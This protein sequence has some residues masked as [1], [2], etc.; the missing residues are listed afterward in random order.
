MIFDLDRLLLC[1]AVSPCTVA[2]Q[3]LLE[4]VTMTHNELAA[5]MITNLMIDEARATDREE[6]L[7]WIPE[8]SAYN[9]DF[10]RCMST[11]FDILKRLGIK[12]A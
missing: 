11:A 10:E 4:E 5:L 1:V 2:R 9:A 12:Q 6:Y 3:E 7:R 8:K